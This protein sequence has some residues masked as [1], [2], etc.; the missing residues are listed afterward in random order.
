MKKYKKDSLI[1][2]LTNVIDNF[3]ARDKLFGPWEPI[4]MDCIDRN[5]ILQSSL[6]FILKL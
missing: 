6:F 5:S 3:E 1:I 2:N 4:V